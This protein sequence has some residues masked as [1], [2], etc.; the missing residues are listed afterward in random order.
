MKKMMAAILMVV[1]I[2]GCG[3]PVKA[4]D[5][6]TTT[7]KLSWTATGDDSLTGRATSYDLRYSTA[8]ITAANFSAATRFAATP[9]PAVSGA[10]D[11]VVVTGLNPTT[12]YYFALKI[13]DEVPNWSGL[14]NVATATTLAPPDTIPPAAIRD[15]KIGALFAK[16]VPLPVLRL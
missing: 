3:A 11:S 9:L 1:V 4:A 12:T 6:T 15:L 8:P 10:R 14:S 5:V 13:A 16:V 7:V 2:G